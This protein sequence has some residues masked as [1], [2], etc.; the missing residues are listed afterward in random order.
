MKL[1][2]IMFVKAINWI[3]K[4]AQEAELIVSDGN[5]ELLCFSQPCNKK[6]NESI[7]S[8]I[9]CFDA[10]DIQKSDERIAYTNKDDS[11]FGYSMCCNL[12]DLKDK[13][14]QIGEIKLCLEGEEFPGDLVEGDY[15]K[16]N[17]SRLDV[18]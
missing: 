12:L 8:L 9:Y 13:I 1:G 11:Y 10:E 4:D 16:F 3:D 7:D 14:V 17:V 15:V 6:V 2:K 18:Y 5:I